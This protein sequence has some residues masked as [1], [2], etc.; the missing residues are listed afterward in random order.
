MKVMLERD[1]VQCVP[2]IG[3]TNWAKKLEGEIEPM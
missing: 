2:V 3:L 1:Q